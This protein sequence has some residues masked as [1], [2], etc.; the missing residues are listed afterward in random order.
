MR[1]ILTL[2]KKSSKTHYIVNDSYNGIIV[3]I[4]TN[5]DLLSLNENKFLKYLENLTRLGYINQTNKI[6]DNDQSYI[7]DFDSKKIEKFNINKYS[8]YFFDGFFIPTL[9]FEI[10]D[11]KENINEHSLWNLLK[12]SLEHE[13]INAKVFLFYEK[14]GILVDEQIDLDHLGIDNIFNF[15]IEYRKIENNPKLINNYGVNL[16]YYSDEIN[17]VKFTFIP[18]KWVYI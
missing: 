13:T 14:E 15:I 6:E 17:L 3:N 11:G 12:K 5:L 4:L 9:F 7:I 1:N 2:I 10:K 16:S 18:K 8:D